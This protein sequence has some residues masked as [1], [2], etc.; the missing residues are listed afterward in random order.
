[1]NRDFQLVIRLIITHQMTITTCK[2][3]GLVT[4]PMPINNSPKMYLTAHIRITHY[5]HNRLIASI[6][7]T[8]D[9]ATSL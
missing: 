9:Q 6:H 3:K 1:M 5:H 2:T 8:K 7:N 4:L